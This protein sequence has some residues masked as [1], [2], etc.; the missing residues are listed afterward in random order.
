MAAA[1]VHRPTAE[2]HGQQVYPDLIGKAA[3]LLQALAINHPLIDGN[4]RT[5][6]LACVTFLALHGIQ[7]RPDIDAAEPKRRSASGICGDCGQGHRPGGVLA[8]GRGGMEPGGMGPLR[9][10]PPGDRVARCER[11]EGGLPC[12]VRSPVFVSLT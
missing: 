12:R 8:S 1:H 6:W 4:K 9:E 10:P 11:R 3:A 2:M 5:A 7:L